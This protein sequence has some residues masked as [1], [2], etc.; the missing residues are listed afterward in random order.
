MNR[1][2]QDKVDAFFNTH[3][4]YYAS[5]HEPEQNAD[6]LCCGLTGREGSKIQFM[7]GNKITRR[8]M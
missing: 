3:G 5:S 4:F 1:S 8:G 6:I 2:S 7:W